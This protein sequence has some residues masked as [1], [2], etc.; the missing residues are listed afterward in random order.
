MSG[1]IYMRHV[2]DSQDILSYQ[3]AIQGQFL[4]QKKLFLPD[5]GHL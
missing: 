4:S 2:F 3:N 5:F 1:V